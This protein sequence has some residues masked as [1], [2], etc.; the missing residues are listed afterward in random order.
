MDAKPNIKASD[1]CGVILQ[2]QACSTSS[3]EYNWSIEVD[4]SEPKLIPTTNDNEMMKILQITDIHYDPNYEVNGNAGCAEPTCC[5]MGQNSTNKNGKLAKYW[6]DYNF[7][8]A[9]WHAV[10]DAL[11]HMKTAHSVFP[12]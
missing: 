3:S 4:N 12:F 9:P 1:V 5:R 2:S 7:C 10:V 11:D 8:D 6:G